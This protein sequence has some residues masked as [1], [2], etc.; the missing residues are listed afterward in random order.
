MRTWGSG[1]FS[2]CFGVKEKALWTQGVAR[3][4]SKG[5]KG[6]F[7]HLIGVLNVVE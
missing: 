5:V 7:S 4:S 3:E 1:I 6:G 2:S